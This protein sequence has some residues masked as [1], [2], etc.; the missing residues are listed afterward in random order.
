M[1]VFLRH[2][3]YNLVGGY[4]DLN[5]IKKYIPTVI[6]A[7]G[8]LFFASKYYETNTEQQLPFTQLVDTDNDRDIEVKDEREPKTILVQV[9]GAAVNTG[10]VELK[11]GDRVKDAIDAAGGVLPDADVDSLNMA[12]KVK[13]EEKI[14][15]PK[16]GERVETH[17][18]VS[19]ELININKANSVELQ[20][21]PG[22][23]PKTA[24]KIVRYRESN[25]FVNVE[26]IKNVPGIG[27][28]KY[29]E[30]KDFITCD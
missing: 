22:I 26:D 14:Y 25:P 8:L 19:N 11:E 23:G 16:V 1:V 3:L 7:I 18:A 2:I 30:I 6:L 15:I 29:E 5:R 10:I 24:D 27:D 20:N 9:A 17:T 28:K 13:D 4:M 12:R 21:I